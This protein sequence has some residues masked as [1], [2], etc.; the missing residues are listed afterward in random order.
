MHLS[1]AVALLSLLLMAACSPSRHAGAD[2]GAPPS[3][4]SLLFGRTGGLGGQMQGHSIRADGTVLRWDGKAPEERVQAEGHLDPDQ[5]AALWARVQE[6]DVF[7]MQR[8]DMAPTVTFVNVTAHGDSRRVAWH[9]PL[10]ET[11]PDTPIQ[12]L[13]DDLVAAARTA[14]DPSP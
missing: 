1:P 7:S 8:Q 14:L 11:P 5:M 2:A 10:G 4:L 12:G 6:A 13:Y 3:D 9:V